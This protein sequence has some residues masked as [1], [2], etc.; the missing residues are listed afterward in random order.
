LEVENIVDNRRGIVGP[1][2]KPIFT[3]PKLAVIKTPRG[4][5]LSPQAIEAVGQMSGCSVIN[6]PMDCEI[7]MGELALK[8][9]ESLHHGIHAILEVPDAVFDKEETD[10]LYAALK[11]LCEK[12]EPGDGSKEVALVK[13]VKKLTE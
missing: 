2:G 1:T 11:Y 5:Q 10:I 12:T 8:E 13:K 3:E 4:V 7:L 9:L 6:V